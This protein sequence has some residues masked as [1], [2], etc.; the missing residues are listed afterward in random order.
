MKKNR[1]DRGK[2]QKDM[3]YL[4]GFGFLWI[5]LLFYALPKQSTIII[6]IFIALVLSVIKVPF[7]INE[8][9]ARGFI[10]PSLPW[11]DKYLENTSKA[12]DKRDPGLQ[13]LAAFT[14][15]FI[16]VWLL[17]IP[18]ISKELFNESI[19]GLVFLIACLLIETGMV[20]VYY[21]K[22]IYRKIKIDE[23]AKNAKKHNKT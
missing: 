10:L 23:V 8:F 12:N 3:I 9:K 6:C 15:M 2:F 21:R 7:Y 1:V 11:E 18:F 17:A 19:K 13:R 22:E 20:G 5:A 16:G 4:F 14:I